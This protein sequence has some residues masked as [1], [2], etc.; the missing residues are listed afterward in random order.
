MLNKLKLYIGLLVIPMLLLQGCGGPSEDT[1]GSFGD[2][3]EELQPGISL[4]MK[5]ASNQQVSFSLMETEDAEI[6]L[7][8]ADDD[9]VI[10]ARQIVDITVTRGS[11]ILSQSTVLTNENGQATVYLYAP[12]VAAGSEPGSIIA[13][14]NGF[15]S[16]PLNYEFIASNAVDPE[17]VPTG[18][19]LKMTR[20]SDGV[21]ENSIT[22]DQVANLDITLYDSQGNRLSDEIVNLTATSGTLSQSSVLTDNQG[23][24]SVTIEPPENLVFGSAPGTITASSGVTTSDEI[25]NYEFVATTQT[26]DGDP[27][28]ATEIR[29]DSVSQDYIS[30]KGSGNNGYGE[31]AQVNFT[32]LNGSTTVAN[33]EV[34]FVLTTYVGG[35]SFVDNL[36]TVSAT[37]D[38]QGRVSAR[39]YAGNVATPVRVTAFIELENGET[40]FVQSNIITVTSGIPDQNSISLSL[41]KFSAEGLNLDGDKVTVTA[42]LADRFN[43]PVPIGTAVS[44]T[45]EGGKIGSSCITDENS[46]C[47]VVWESQNPRPADHRSTILAHV[48]GHETFYDENGSGVFDDVGTVS[49]EF[50]DLTEAF[51]DDDENGIF[52]PDAYD[53]SNFNNT[54]SRDEIFIDY[55]GSATFSLGDNDFNGFPCNHSTDCPANANNL[56]G[57]SNS[58]INV[59]KEALVIM[60]TSFANIELRTIDAGFSTCLDT[61]GKIRTDICNQVSGINFPN[62]A[63][64]EKLWIL[65]EDSAALCTTA[66][67]DYSINPYEGGSPQAYFT[68]VDAVSPNDSACTFAT[69][70]SA[71]TGSN[72]DVSTEVGELSEIPVTKVLNTY[73]HLEFVAFISSS[74]ENEQDDSGALTIKVTS[75]DGGISSRAISIFDPAF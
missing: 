63:N 53:E 68:R 54:F 58:L 71:A 26:G 14:S 73:G 13:S 20:A 10:Q 2:G 7:I 18:I 34:S 47:S 61:N 69:R 16:E 30:L 45:T 64:T 1:Q 39:V 56:A 60:A 31:S 62:G 66:A 32:V 28:V 49:D 33:A 12:D 70:Q 65:I 24:A 17:T 3:F 5:N 72:I 19:Q 41:D 75:P 59:R 23:N 74:D 25:L 6:N 37:T 29:F 21:E 57:R 4:I 50:E 51:R 38:A 36:E 43:N 22:I 48:I 40:I 27:L 44:F 35:L 9:G 67:P 55:D 42:R 46:Q 8:F 15:T 11:A 52:D